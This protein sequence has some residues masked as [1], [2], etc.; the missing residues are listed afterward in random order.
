MT[1]PRTQKSKPVTEF[2][3]GYQRLVEMPTEMAIA[4]QV[5]DD[6]IVVV[7]PQEK[8]SRYGEMQLRKRRVDER[9]A[10]FTADQ[11]SVLLKSK[12]PSTS[13]CILT[14]CFQIK[15]LQRIPD[16]V[17]TFANVA[18]LECKHSSCKSYR[19]FDTFEALAYHLN[20]THHSV[21]EDGHQCYLCDSKTYNT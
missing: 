20:L 16:D 14:I 17:L 2:V 18:N 19:P 10:T 15:I 7:M 3:G 1:L 8:S 5:P 12:T 6:R 9:Y 11:V 21:G 13:N 4:S